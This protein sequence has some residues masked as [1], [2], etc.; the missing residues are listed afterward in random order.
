MLS[1]S[2]CC[3]I[4][5]KNEFVFLD[6][7]PPTVNYVYGQKFMTNLNYVLLCLLL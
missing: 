4:K 2:S 1:T 7:E 3:L 5:L 6:Q